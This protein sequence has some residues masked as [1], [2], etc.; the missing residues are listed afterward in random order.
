MAPVAAYRRHGAGFRQPAGRRLT[1]QEFHC[2]DFTLDQSSYR[3]QRGD[4]LLSLEKI[5]M[6]LLLLLLQ[7]HGELV[8]CEEIHAYLWGKDVFLEVDHGINTAI[9]KVRLALHDD[10][11][12]PRFI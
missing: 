8:S 5:P 9:R 3:L 2:G 10:P 12:K 4:R 11:D 6:E 1:A 7:R